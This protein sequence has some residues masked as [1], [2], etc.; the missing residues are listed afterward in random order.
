MVGILGL[1]KQRLVVVSIAADLYR[2]VGA[3]VWYIP[4][5]A[6]ELGIGS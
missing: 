3:E 5:L 2:H 6:I 4:E 1:L